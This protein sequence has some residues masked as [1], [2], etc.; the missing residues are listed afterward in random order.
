[1]QEPRVL[2]DSTCL[3]EALD[4]NKLTFPYEPTSDELTSSTRATSISTIKREEKERSPGTAIAG[5][6]AGKSGMAGRSFSSFGT[7]PAVE[8]DSE[9]RCSTLASK[10]CVANRKDDST[11][12]P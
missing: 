4:S 3:E 6:T 7:L 12:L 9:V 2:L 10:R 11:K 8:I 1:M 5:R